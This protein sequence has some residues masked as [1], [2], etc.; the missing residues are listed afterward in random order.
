L[1][2]I[3]VRK[4]CTVR[5]VST[6]ARHADV[7][8]QEATPLPAQADLYALATGLPLVT[9]YA[10]LRG[11]IVATAARERL[12]GTTLSALVRAWAEAGQHAER[13][14]GRIAA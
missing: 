9:V 11:D 8:W 10:W 2:L 3:F 6:R 5:L 13:A 1:A 7:S 4:S 12:E 14:R